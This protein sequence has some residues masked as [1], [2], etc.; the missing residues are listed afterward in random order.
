MCLM[1]VIITCLYVSIYND[2]YMKII[3]RFKL[4]EA[5]STKLC[6]MYSIKLQS[7]L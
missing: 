4:L 5:N 6:S 1:D 3:E 7:P 2:I